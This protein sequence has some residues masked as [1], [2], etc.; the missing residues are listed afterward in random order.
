MIILK[1]V[2]GAIKTLIICGFVE[3]VAPGVSYDATK[4]VVEL[5]LK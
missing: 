3:Y 4:Y 5:M 2:I 1:I